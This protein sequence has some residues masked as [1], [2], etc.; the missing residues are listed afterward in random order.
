M[1]SRKGNQ[2]IRINYQIVTILERVVALPVPK[3]LQVDTILL[4]ATGSAI[5][6]ALLIQWNIIP[7]Y[8]NLYKNCMKKNYVYNLI[9]HVDGEREKPFAF[10]QHAEVSQKIIDRILPKIYIHIC[11]R[12]LYP[13]MEKAFAFGIRF[14]RKT[15]HLLFIC[16][17]AFNDCYENENKLK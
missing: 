8:E 17:A 4:G 3:I 2:S 1:L 14:H 7:F 6:S 16:E 15:Q 13:V 5:K 11:C 9:L 10:V 12:I